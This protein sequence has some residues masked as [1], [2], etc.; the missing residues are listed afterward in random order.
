LSAPAANASPY[1]VTL[2]RNAPKNDSNPGMG[3][4]QS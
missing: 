1:A 4:A 3:L 2:R